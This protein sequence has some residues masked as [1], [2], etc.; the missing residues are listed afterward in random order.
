LIIVSL[1]IFLPIIQISIKAWNLDSNYYIALVES[2]LLYEGVLNTIELILKVGIF[3]AIIGFT[4]AYI[5]TF[6]NVKFRSI[7]NILLILPLG[8]PVYVAAY[9]Y[10]NIYYSLPF[11]EDIFRSD[12]FMNGAMFI[13]VMFLYPYVYIASKSYLSKNL[14]EY[15]E[16]ARTLNRSKLYTLFKVV[17]PLS[18]PVIIG[19]VLFAIFETLS[20]FAVVEYYGELTLSRYINI[21]WFNQGDINTASRFAVYVLVLIYIFISIEKFSRRNKRYTDSSNVLRKVKKENFTVLSGTLSYLF[22][23]IITMLSFVL[24]VSRMIQSAIIRYEYIER[25]DLLEIVGNTLIITVISIFIILVT[26]IL[27]TT[28]IYT[29]KSKKKLFLSNLLIMG[30]SIPSMVLALGAYLFFIQ[31]D[32][33]IYPLISAIGI[34]KMLVTSTIAL[35]VIGFFLKFFSIGYSNLLSAYNKIDPNLLEVSETLGENKL[36]TMVRVSIP[37]LSKSIFGI[38]IILCIDMI[39]DLTLVYSLR[40]FNFKTLSTEVY[41]YAGNEMVDVAAFPSLVII[42]ICAVLI[43]F[44]EEGVK[45]VKF[46]KH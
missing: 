3:S 10:T 20:D 34:N 39:K 46:K 16:S 15:L 35:I 8:I 19:S 40:P 30:Y 24:P 41:R 1:F 2:N 38:S 13:Y 12:F 21:A 26:S 29:M 17:L 14:T 5:M 32:R 43:V 25:L 7:L 31:F 45:H 42:F 11:L 28:I 44:L 22:I 33:T 4:L 9:T 18:R 27:I 36:S 37:I 6:Y 23:G